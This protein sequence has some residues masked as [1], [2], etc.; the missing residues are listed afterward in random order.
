M[1]RINTGKE[2][3]IHFTESC[4]K[5]I[6]Q[7]QLINILSWWK[8]DTLRNILIP[9]LKVPRYTNS[10]SLNFTICTCQWEI[11]PRFVSTRNEL[12]NKKWIRRI[13]II[14]LSSALRMIFVTPRFHF[15]KTQFFVIIIK[16]QHNNAFGGCLLSLTR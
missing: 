5:E 11:W 2:M 12:L 6:F 1:S 7:C 16:K 9:H 10:T 3:I 15:G 14:P 4:W 13:S 8:E